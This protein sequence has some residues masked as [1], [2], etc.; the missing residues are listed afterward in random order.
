MPSVGKKSV[1]ASG[2]Y[3]FVDRD[4]IPTWIF[5]SDKLWREVWHFS[6]MQNRL[7]A[8]NE[9]IIHEPQRKVRD[10]DKLWDRMLK[11]HFNT[12]SAQS[13]PDKL[14]TLPL[15]SVELWFHNHWSLTLNQSDMSVDHALVLLLPLLLQI[16]IF[17]EDRSWKEKVYSLPGLL[18]CKLSCPLQTEDFCFKRK[19]K[20]TLFE[21][22]HYWL[23][24]FTRPRLHKKTMRQVHEHA[25]TTRMHSSRMRT[26]R[27]RVV[28]GGRG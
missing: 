2:A 22:P 12:H 16:W 4:L 19:Q 1:S 9:S 27:L 21:K 10:L 8:Q 11:E 18:H 23:D 25:K 5:E 24:T 7:P 6:P 14:S 15:T 17:V 3:M 20:R 28:W 26:A 13:T